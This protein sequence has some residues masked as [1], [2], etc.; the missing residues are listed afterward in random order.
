MAT[1]IAHIRVKPGSETAFEE[2]A[3]RLYRAT[4]DSETGVRRYEYWR[5]AEPRSYYTVLAFEDFPTFIAHQTSEHHESAAA[6]LGAVIESLRLEWVD[7]VAGA[8]DLPAT[9]GGGI[10]ADADELTERYSRRFAAEI[11]GW[12]PR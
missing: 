5:G 10:A 7:P 11:A 4:H 6:E 2:I 12:W 8:S 3:R 9:H 1:I